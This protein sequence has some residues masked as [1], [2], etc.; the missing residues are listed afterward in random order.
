MCLAVPSKVISISGKEAE[1]ETGGVIRRVGI[2]LTPDVKTGDYVLVHA[3]YAISVIDPHEAEEQL[4][5][6]SQ[7]LEEVE[8]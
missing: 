3:G 8:R 5:L 2:I 6:L 7:L 4:R 1:V